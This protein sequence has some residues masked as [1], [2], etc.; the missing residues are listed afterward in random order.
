MLF[1]ARV[2]PK[3]KKIGRVDFNLDQFR[4]LMEQ[5]GLPV[6]WEQTAVCPCSIPTS[7][8]GMDLFSVNDVSTG[9]DNDPACTTCGGKGFIRYDEQEINVLYQAHA[10]SNDT[11]EYGT[12]LNSTAQLTLLPEHLPRFGDRFRV[13]DSAIIRSEKLTKGAGNTVTLGYTVVTRQLD[14]A[15]GLTPAN[16]LAVFINDATGS[17]SFKLDP[18][19]YSFNEANNSITFLAGLPGVN[20]PAD[21][22]EF[23][24][25]YY[26]NPEFVVV[27]HPY[28]VRDTVI[29]KKGVES[30]KAMPVQCEVRLE[31]E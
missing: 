22:S 26:T 24:I 7:D 15:S 31:S 14:L 23:T 12:S 2:P 27:S 11:L 3:A 6:V 9:I 29:L 19:N 21:D 18:L 10:A 20:K 4:I 8:A 13:K 25:V 17:N 16:I 28:I 30:K 5:K 1:P